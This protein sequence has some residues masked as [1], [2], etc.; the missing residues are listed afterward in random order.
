MPPRRDAAKKRGKNKSES[1][2]SRWAYWQSQSGESDVR[3]PSRLNRQQ[4]RMAKRKR[5][6]IE[7]FI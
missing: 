1:L 5:K 7:D 6:Q 4:R 2:E 3:P